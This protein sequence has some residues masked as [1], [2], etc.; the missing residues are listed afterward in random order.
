MPPF[1]RTREACVTGLGAGVT[2][3]GL[4]D[5]KGFSVSTRDIVR[6]RLLHRVLR[7]RRPQSFKRK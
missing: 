6:E 4:S 3:F 1:E 7:G 2:W 5:Q